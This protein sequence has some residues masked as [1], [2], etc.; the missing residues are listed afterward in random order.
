MRFLTSVAAINLSG[1]CFVWFTLRSGPFRDSSEMRQESALP[2]E[3]EM[4]LCVPL[5][6]SPHPVPMASCPA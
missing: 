2:A 4:Q 6:F 1:F 5:P 3:S